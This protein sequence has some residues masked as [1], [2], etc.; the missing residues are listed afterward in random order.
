M[1][2]GLT[3]TGS[4][5]LNVQSAAADGSPVRVALKL[6]P[7]SSARPVPLQSANAPASLPT[8]VKPEN[9]RRVAANQTVPVVQA[10]AARPAIGTGVKPPAAAKP[11]PAAPQAREVQAREG[12]APEVQA[13]DKGSNAAE[14][15]DG[16]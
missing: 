5:G 11:T 10:Q 13:E 2:I 9:T 8:Q 4:E 3:H 14:G 7:A 15:L 12:I 1:I 16:A 6:P